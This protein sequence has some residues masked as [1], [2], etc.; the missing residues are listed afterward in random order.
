MCT[1]IA[2]RLSVSEYCKE[3]RYKRIQQWGSVYLDTARR[4]GVNEKHSETQ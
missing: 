4:L 1:K 2:V 3:A